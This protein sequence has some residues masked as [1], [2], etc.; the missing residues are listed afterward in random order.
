[1]RN[2]QFLQFALLSLLIGLSGC[3]ASRVHTDLD[4]QMRF[5]V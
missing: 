2:Q 1:M 5:E 3:S 4:P